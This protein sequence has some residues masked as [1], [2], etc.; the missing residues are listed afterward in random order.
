MSRSLHKR[1]IALGTLA[2][3]PLNL[4]HF[5]LRYHED[6]AAPQLFMLYVDTATAF[7]RWLDSGHLLLPP[8]P[9]PNTSCIMTLLCSHCKGGVSLELSLS[10]LHFRHL[11]LLS[12]HKII[13]EATCR[14]PVLACHIGRSPWGLW[15]P[16]EP[17]DARSR[18]RS[19]AFDGST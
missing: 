10:R 17:G 7:S 6:P 8:G 11:Y 4:L 13:C 5:K 14:R 3:P 19:G 18:T 9:R 1:R 15:C 2:V 12:L 16:T